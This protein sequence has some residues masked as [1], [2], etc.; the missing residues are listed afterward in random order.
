MQILIYDYDYDKSDWLIMITTLE[1]LLEI[2]KCVRALESIIEISY[3]IMIRK[4]CI[5]KLV[6]VLKQKWLKSKKDDCEEQA[7]ENQNQL[8]AERNR[9][10]SRRTR[11]VLGRMKGY[12]RS[13]LSNRPHSEHHKTYGVVTASRSGSSSA[14]SSPLVLFSAAN[15]NGTSRPEANSV[16]IASVLVGSNSL[17]LSTQIFPHSIEPL[18]NHVQY[19]GHYLTRVLMC[20]SRVVCWLDSIV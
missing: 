19:Q 15:A 6:R 13:S 8:E 3:T 20:F 2:I 14:S 11:Q 17:P 7:Y 18:F 12:L 16:A 5:W 1:L 9:S 10:L 4:K